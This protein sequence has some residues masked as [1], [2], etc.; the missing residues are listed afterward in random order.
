MSAL[1][2]CNS[3]AV[4]GLRPCLIFARCS[5]FSRMPFEAQASPLLFLRFWR[6][7]GNG[8]EARIQMRRVP[9]CKETFSIRMGDGLE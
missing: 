5:Y 6:K 4:V 9:Y 1:E 3:P 7:H 8:S 2:A